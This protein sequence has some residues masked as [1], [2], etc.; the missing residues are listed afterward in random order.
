MKIKKQNK[1]WQC[2]EC[3]SGNQTVIFEGNSRPNCTPLCPKIEI[4]WTFKVKLNY[5]WMNFHKN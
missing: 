5:Y 2:G 4:K 3:K 1:G